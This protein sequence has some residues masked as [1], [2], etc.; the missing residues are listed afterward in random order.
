MINPRIPKDG[1]DDYTHVQTDDH[2]QSSNGAQAWEGP[3]AS[4]T[5]PLSA[6][7]PPPPPPVTTTS[8]RET[9][10]SPRLGTVAVPTVPTSTPSPLPILPSPTPTPPAPAATPSTD[11]TRL[12]S[13]SLT[14]ELPSAT[15]N[16]LSTSSSTTRTTS[17]SLSPASSSS[18][19][20]PYP[21]HV[22]TE[23]VAESQPITFVTSASALMVSNIPSKPTA[24]SASVTSIS[25]TAGVSNPYTDPA[26]AE[27][28]ENHGP[29]RATLVAAVLIPMAAVA[30]LGAI[31]FFLLRRR[32]KGNSPH[33]AAVETKEKLMRGDSSASRYTGPP[34]DPYP[35]VFAHYSAPPP[36]APLMTQNE[37]IP[38]I[39]STTMSSTYFT[40]LDTSEANS[41]H[42]NNNAGPVD[43]INY[44]RLSG[45]EPPPPYRTRSEAAQ[46]Q[47]STNSSLRHFEATNSSNI[48]LTTALR[49]D[50]NPFADPVEEFDVV[51]PVDGGGMARHYGR[52]SDELSAVS[53][54]SYQNPFRDGMR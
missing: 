10:A 52:D 4:S 46:S 36:D 1:G 5:S 29:S 22:Y 21:L 11:T 18:S 33:E 34:P 15:R 42:S 49:A 3:A 20:L 39:L 6:P 19:T 26:Q 8:S 53:D 16:V 47:R 51:S 25:N 7:S 13:V 41:L 30:L 9:I 31:V 37:A 14:S 28:L 35:A 48:C 44:N 43:G 17:D 54:L 40:G 27:T 32:R 38:V 24:S 12:A 50:S 23:P 45:E 2:P